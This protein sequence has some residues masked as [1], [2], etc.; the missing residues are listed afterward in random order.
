M[1]FKAKPYK[2]IEAIFSF[3]ISSYISDSSILFPL[4]RLL[5]IL[6]LVLPIVPVTGQEINNLRSREF[7][8]T[9]DSMIIDSMHV[10][11]GSFFLYNEAGRL[12]P[13]KSYMLHYPSAVLYFDRE[14]EGSRVKALYRV[15][16][17]NLAKPYANKDL[18]VIQE[19]SR[20]GYNPFTIPS[21][22]LS[23]ASYYSSTELDKRGSL[24]R[25][26][27]F[28]N[29]QDV[30]VNSN[31]NLQLNGKIS[32]DLRIVAAISDNNIPIQ[33]E[34]TSQQIHE[35]DKVFIEVFN[36]QLSLTAGDFDLYGSPGTF[37]DFAKKG[38]GIKFTG[39]FPV[40]KDP[41]RTIVTTVSG[42]ISKGKFCRQSFTGSEGNQGPYKL[43]GCNQEQ[44]IIV[45]AGAEKVYIDGR[46][47]QRGLDNDYVIDYNNAEITFTPNQLIT[48]D[49]RII[50]EFEY[51]ERSYARFLVYSG[52]EFITEKSYF[53]INV[54]AE[55]DDKNQT[56]QQD[57]S[58]ANKYLLAGIGDHLDQAVTLRADSVGFNN[59]E[60]LYKKIDTLVQGTQ[61]NNVY[62]YSAHPDSAW[63]R[64]GFSFVGEGNGHYRQ[65]KAS[66][67]GKTYKWIAPVNGIPQGNYE[68]VVLLITPKKKQLI[69]VGGSAE[70]T[71]STTSAF[72][73]TLSNNDI[74]TFSSNDRQDNIG[75]ALKGIISQDVLL[76]DTT[77]T[78]L[79]ATGS[80]QLISNHFDP[81]ER[82]RPVEFERDWNITGDHSGGNEHN[83]SVRIDYF[84]KER[85]RAGI[86]SEFLNRADLYKG[87]R[88]QG[89]AD[90]NAGGFQ[91]HLKG[92]LLNSD[93]SYQNTKFIRHDADISRQLKYIVLGVREEGE[94]N[95][96]KDAENDSLLGNS[97]SYQE[98][99]IYLTNPD[100]SKN[101]FMANYLMRTDYSVNQNN[102]DPA[103]TANDLNVGFGLVKNP[104][105]RLNTVLTYRTLRINDSVLTTEV[106]DEFLLARIDH[107]GRIKKGFI[108]TSTYYEI[109]SG[110][111][112]EKEFSY[113]EV[114][115]GQGVYTWSDYNKNNIRELDE[116]EVAN[117]QDQAGYIRVFTPTDR[118][119][120]VFSNQF[121]QS[122]NLQP[123]RIWN[124]QEG[125][126]KLVARF[127]NLLAF[128]IN[129]KMTGPDLIKN[130]NPF[131]IRLTNPDLTSMTTS[132]RNNLSFNKSGDMVGIDYIYQNNKNRLSLVNGFDTRTRLSN[133]LRIKW[134]IN[135]SISIINQTDI[136]SKG[137]ESEFFTNKNY[138]IDFVTS[139]LS[140]QYQPGISYRIILNYTY[141]NEN[142][143]SNSELAGT[144]D[145]GIEGRYN[146]LNKG[147][148]SGKVNYVNITYNDLLNTPVAYEMLQ[149]LLPGHN[150]VWSILLQRTITGGVD[151]NLEYS[152]R[153][154]EKQDVV[155]VGGITV[156]WNF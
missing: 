102:L 43:R 44:F 42:A 40:M 142:N 86:Q 137:F 111:E 116:F 85:T 109:G 3:I 80:Y 91:F 39:R 7:I 101:S 108:S 36:E 41:D 22:D 131:N 155:H 123:A 95:R 54:Y 57:L 139:N 144:H 20:P 136:G 141:K 16:S 133:G 64:L 152:G 75:F 29:N 11:P 2:P 117:F 110:L 61:Y 83:G 122:I 48:K 24:S 53:W 59:T 84:K 130:L 88:N 68:P 112:A 14:L 28:G 147:N 37:M 115:P 15:I 127:S 118:F 138:D 12:L 120:K 5:P 107:S 77:D 23:A 10:V 146:I 71:A 140:M 52:N 126:K 119:I 81:V 105:N 148:L 33:P 31:L 96:W 58:D 50:V 66:A 104:N 132:I 129:R 153:V 143:K 62:V 76:R 114:A 60:V 17:V 92:S 6:F 73:F 34:G 79:W 100:T 32:D 82:F 8:L 150:G 1:G 38:K 151:L 18:S 90:V 26:I 30:V 78:R 67:N 98:Y 55:Q 74:N 134:N 128:R 93:D 106:K 45:L 124:N 63:F 19:I 121:N 35:F 72:E 27:Q 94:T 46:L 51:S 135:N 113:L 70:L 87:Y 13:E 125:I 65:V 97:F 156:R 21:S 145:V 89:Y 4:K 69:S 9:G 149:G 25:G 47:M 99:E 56:L 49:K 103:T 154:S